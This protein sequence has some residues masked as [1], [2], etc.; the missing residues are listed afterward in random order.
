M[1]FFI[2][3]T[4]QTPSGTPATSPAVSFGPMVTALGDP[5]RWLILAELSDGEP[6]MV[7][8][9]AGA[10]KRSP[11]S[12]SKHLAV[13]RKAGMVVIGQAGLYRIPKQF[14]P[15]P[16]ER[17]VDYGYCLLRLPAKQ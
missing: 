11:D 6:H 5:N 4:P 14:L 15:T 1:M 8:E 12:T 2:M 16:G 13:L 7:V 3:T 9:I 17:V 10:I